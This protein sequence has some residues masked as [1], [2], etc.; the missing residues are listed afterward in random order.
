M[1]KYASQPM[2]WDLVRIFLAVNREG[3]LRAAA[4]QLGIGQTTAGRRLAALERQLGARLF[5]HTPAGY[6]ATAAGEAL[7]ANAERMEEEAYTIERRAAGLDTRLMGTVRISMPEGLMESLIAPVLA[8]LH[9]RYPDL[10]I[11]LWMER[12]QADV[13]SHYISTYQ[14]DIGLR[15]TQPTSSDLI[16]RR[17]GR[18]TVRLYAA[19]CYIA[20]RGVPEPGTHFAEHDLIMPFTPGMPHRITE[21]CGEP[22]TNGRVVLEANTML[23]IRAAAANGMGIAL[24]SPHLAAEEPRLVGIWPDRE[25]E[26]NIWLVAHPD[27]Y[28]AARVRAV[29]DAMIEAFANKG[30]RDSNISPDVGAGS[31]V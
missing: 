1:Q 8:Q 22:V 21:F 11:V 16:T 4:R 20:E 9:E 6:L 25:Q 2:D 5:A 14:A 10:R 31:L 28:K 18:L 12:G 30:R 23:A 17:V 27:V 19:R 3:S 29:M 7:L 26:F 24:L 13:A 15:V